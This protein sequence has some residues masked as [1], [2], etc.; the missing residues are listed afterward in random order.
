MLWAEVI[1][2]PKALSMQ[3]AIEKAR[4]ILESNPNALSLNQFENPANPEAHYLTT[5]REIYEDMQSA[6]RH[7]GH[8]SKK[9]QLDFFVCGA[10][11]GGSFSGITRYLKARSQNPSCAM[12]SYWL[13]DWR[14]GGG[15]CEY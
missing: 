15:V 3:G 6:L 13:C 4:E 12:R 10:G 8:D 11:S 5:A 14:W 1:N 2:T 7:S 9:A